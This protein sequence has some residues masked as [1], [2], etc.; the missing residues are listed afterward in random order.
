ME[1]KTERRGRPAEVAAIPREKWEMTYYEY[2]N[3]A[4]RD[5]GTKTTFYYDKSIFINFFGFIGSIADS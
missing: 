2:S 4:Y 3:E 5:Q 1:I